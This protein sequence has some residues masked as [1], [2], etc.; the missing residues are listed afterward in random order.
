MKR[1]AAALIALL[2]SA[3]VAAQEIAYV[4][5]ILR[6]GIHRAQDTSDRAFENL[7]SGTEL[8]V[9]ERVPN[10][11]RVRTSGG[12]QGWV[13]S[14]Y[15]V[16]EK[17]AQL[18]VAEVEAELERLRAKLDSA[19]SARQTAETQ[20]ERAATEMSTRMSSVEAIED[21]LARLQQENTA[22]EG[23]LDTY[24][25]A[26][27]LAWVGAALAVALI[28]GFAGGI[29]WLDASIRRRHGGFRV[30]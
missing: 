26:L 2:L 15:L 19:E 4:T 23:R 12:Q 3:S 11:A 28:G 6:L 30:Y 22:Y 24:R 13:K 25:G 10:Y 7:V 16:T 21:T 1:T 5:D 9:L 8:E 18:R 20:A 17:P 14:A 29:W 27:P